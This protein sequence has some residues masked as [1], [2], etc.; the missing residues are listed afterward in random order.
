[1]SLIMSN[2]VPHYGRKLRA[3]RPVKVKRFNL[4]AVDMVSESED[5]ST[6]GYGLTLDEANECKA[7]FDALKLDGFAFM[8]LD[9]ATA[10]LL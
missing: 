5:W 3:D 4:I 10:E 8:V 7:S 1:M 2:T 6:L 9:D